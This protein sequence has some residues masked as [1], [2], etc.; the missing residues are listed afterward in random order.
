M[1]DDDDFLPREMPFDGPGRPIEALDT[2]L[3]MW[4]F[5]GSE[6]SLSMYKRFFQNSFFPLLGYSS[7]PEHYARA[8]ASMLNE[9]RT[10]FVAPHVCDEVFDRGAA[11]D[12]IP[13]LESMMPE[14]SGLAVFG[15]AFP[16]VDYDMTIVRDHGPEH[17]PAIPLRAI[18]WNV[19]DHVTAPDGTS[20]R[21]LVLWL[22]TDSGMQSK[23]EFRKQYGAY[24]P[25]CLVIDFTGW[26]FDLE[27]R[28]GPWEINPD[29]PAPLFHETRPHIAQ[30]RMLIMALWDVMEERLTSVRPP[31]P[32]RRRWERS[33][34]KI[35]EDG[36][37]KIIH[38][39]AYEG[40]RYL[41]R[42]GEEVMWSHRW[43]VTGHWAWRA[44]KCHEEGRH[45]VYIAP[46]VKGPESALLVIKE[47]IVSV[48][49]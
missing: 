26:A 22:Y 46:Y 23:E 28:V 49:R 6:A 25:P 7:G 37:V 34:K 1:F 29:S 48:D 44:C 12:P 30:V 41:N 40:R 10:V 14:P 32:Q 8:E 2:H 36:E 18:A 31:R 45:R 15:K 16:Y 13:L 47:K 21:G 43:V 19:S 39:R 3:A 9:A 17:L 27:W 42:N 33:G 38:L 24:P 20:T 35:P 11:Y 5:A 4:E